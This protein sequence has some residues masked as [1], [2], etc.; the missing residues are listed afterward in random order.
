MDESEIQKQFYRPICSEEEIDRLFSVKTSDDYLLRLRADTAVDHMR[1]FR[2][3]RNR[4]LQSPAGWT[5][6]SAFKDHLFGEYVSLLDVDLRSKCSGITSG[7]IFSND[8]NGACSKTPYGNVIVV[9]CALEYFFFYMNMAFLDFGV[10]V[11]GKVRLAAQ[12]I[13]IRTML[14]TEALDFEMDPRGR[15]PKKLVEENNRFVARQMSFIIG[16]EYS[17]HICGHIDGKMTADQPI[18]TA[19]RGELE[20]KPYR[21]YN[22]REIQEFE[23]DELSLLLPRMSKSRQYQMVY[24]ALLCFAYWDLYQQVADQLFPSPPSSYRTHPQPSER[25]WNVFEKVGQRVG[26]P[27]NEAEELILSVSKWKKHFQEDVAINIENY[28]MY[29]S[30]YLAR[31]NTKWRGR[32]LRDRIDYY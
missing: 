30:V 21:F 27:K 18:F 11:P 22:H 5:L 3:L 26:F 16:H 13:A 25:Y 6:A 4:Y 17:H 23:A 2:V 7:L 10:K 28:E 32:E 20:G 29:G 1:I 31:P 8:P 14:K 24:A 9:S 19:M 15:I 12:R